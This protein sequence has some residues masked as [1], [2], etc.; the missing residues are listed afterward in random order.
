M[1]NFIAQ[2][3]PATG[4]MDLTNE[5]SVLLVGLIGLVGCA[6]GALAIMAVREWLAQK[7]QTVVVETPEPA[8]FRQAA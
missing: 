7:P 8:D 4:V 6:T 3:G 1:L 5:L 2:V